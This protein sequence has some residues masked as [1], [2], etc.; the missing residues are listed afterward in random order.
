MKK[1]TSNSK[2]QVSSIQHPESRSAIVK[3]GK[4]KVFGEVH[5]HPSL[6]SFNGHT[7][8]C[9]QVMCGHTVVGFDV[10]ADKTFVCYIHTMDHT[11]KKVYEIKEAPDYGV[12][13]D[14]M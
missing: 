10:F 5:I 2:H 7:L 14:Y 8:S 6:W 13:T 4:L 3:D 12:T 11:Q 9:K 1:Q